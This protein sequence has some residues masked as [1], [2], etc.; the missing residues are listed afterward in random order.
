M[1]VCSARLPRTHHPPLLIPA[2]AA[3]TA[4]Q[5]FCSQTVFSEIKAPK[6]LETVAL[7]KGLL[8]WMCRW[9]HC[10]SSGGGRPRLQ[11]P[12]S[13]QPGQGAALCVLAALLV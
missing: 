1:L 9:A 11:R 8:R 13:S 5:A 12:Y 2:V 4:W 10:R 6:L 3:G 7:Q